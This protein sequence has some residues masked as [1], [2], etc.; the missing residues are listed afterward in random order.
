L[1]ILEEGEAAAKVE[2][3]KA[4]AQD[5]CREAPR[6]RLHYRFVWSGILSID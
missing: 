3:E 5:A 4:E 6:G 1:A 2:E